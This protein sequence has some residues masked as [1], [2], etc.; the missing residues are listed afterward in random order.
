M[1]RL[2]WRE[3]VFPI[4]RPKATLVFI[5]SS[6]N[7]DLASLRIQKDMIIQVPRDE[8]KKSC[9]STTNIIDF[10]LYL[11]NTKQKQPFFNMAAK[12]ST[13]AQNTTFNG[14]PL[15]YSRSQ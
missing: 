3:A 13:L 8:T 12:R 1:K 5:V 14:L 11:N 6:I 15:S 7:D 9:G 10:M 4:W 2:V